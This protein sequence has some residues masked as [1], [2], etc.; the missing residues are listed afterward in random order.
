M[1]ICGLSRR[2]SV[3]A[4]SSAVVI[5][6]SPKYVDVCFFSCCRL[7]GVVCV[8][9][10]DSSNRGRERQRRRAEPAA[11]LRSD[12][13]SRL[14]RG[15]DGRQRRVLRPGQHQVRTIRSKLSR[16]REVS[17]V[18]LLAVCARCFKTSLPCGYH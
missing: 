2:R 10:A 11:V 14:G 1:S 4:L 7:Y 3:G 16:R 17:V 18:R 9:F 13:R 12:R 15:A 8:V 5:L 6:C